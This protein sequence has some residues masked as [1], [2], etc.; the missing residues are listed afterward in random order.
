MWYV[1]VGVHRDALDGTASLSV[2]VVVFVVW[3]LMMGGVPKMACFTCCF[4]SGDRPSLCLW[5]WCK[6]RRVAA[7]NGAATAGG[8]GGAAACCWTAAAQGVKR[9]KE[10]V[11]RVEEEREGAADH[12]A[13]RQF[14]EPRHGRA[15]RG[16]AATPPPPVRTAP[17]RLLT[18]MA[19]PLP[20]GLQQ[21]KGWKE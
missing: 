4:V 19:E 13:M 6:G 16:G 21:L 7:E 20:F 5:S 2:Y 17:S 18:L 8:H 9:E 3:L 10:S 1:C 15:A 11:E 12:S 14:E